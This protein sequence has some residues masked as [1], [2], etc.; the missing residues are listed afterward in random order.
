MRLRRILVGL[1]LVWCRPAAAQQ[2][3][4]YANEPYVVEQSRTSE[5][6]ENDGTGTREVYFR[7]KV[8][9]DAGVQRF[10]QLALG[11][12]A[13]NESIAIQFVRVR[14]PDGTVITTPLDT[15]QDLSSPV[16]R[17]AP[18][19][20]DF[21]QKHVTVE[22]IR[23]GDTL[24]ADVITTIKTALA[25]GEFWTEYSF[26]QRDISLD[27]QFDLD[28]PASRKIIL[29]VQPGFD[30]TT[31]DANGRRIYHWSHANTVRKDPSDA[32]KKKPRSSTEPERASVRVTTFADW[33]AVG[34][35]FAG[36]E[37]NARTITPEI[38]QKARELTAGKPTDLAK[39]EALYDFVSK[40]F[41]YVSLSLGAGRYQP[42]AASDVLKD[43][44]GDC[45]DKATLLAALIQASGMQASPVLI[46]SSVKLDPDFPSPSQFDHV[47]TRATLNGRE[48]WLD[49]TPQ[50]APFRLLAPSLRDKQALLAAPGSGSHL[51]ETPGDT[52]FPA[53]TET[54]VSG[55]LDDSGTLSADVTLTFRGDME[56]AMRT[57]FHQAPAA[58][59][60]PLL[61]AV[62]R[63][64]G[65]AG[66]VS[67]IKPS[68]PLDT[69]SAFSVSFHVRSPDF[70]ELAGR[71]LDV[72]LPMSASQTPADPP[73]DGSI[74]L[75]AAG[76]AVYSL[77][78][79]V[80]AGVRIQLPVPVNVTR[81]Y[82]EYH[83]TYS[84]AGAVL[85]ASRTLVLHQHELPQTRRSDYLAFVHVIEGD[86]NQKVSLDATALTPPAA[87]AGTD[88]K[89]LSTRAY[90]ALQAGD[91]EQSAAM[92]EQLL[93]ADPKDQNARTSL[94]SAYISLHQPQK[95]L[96]VLRQQ[97]AQ[98]PY[99]EY[100]YFYMGR[101]Y[102][103]EHQYAD[104]EAAFNKQLEINPLDKFVPGALGA[105]D[106]ERGQYDKAAAA[107][108]RAVSL[109]PDQW[110][111]LVQLGKAY[112]NLHRIADAQNAFDRAVQIAPA[113]GTWNDVAYEMALGGIN[114]DTAQ[115]YAE[116]AVAAESAASRNLDIQQ[117]DDR[118]LGV[119][120]GLASFWDTL[121]WVH[122][123]KGDL[124]GAEPYVRAAWLLG[125]T[126]DVADHLGQ[127]FEKQG[128]RDEALRAY[129]EAAAAPDPENDVRP[130]L[131]A[132]ARGDKAADA[133]VAKYRG[134][135]AASMTFKLPG[136]GRSGAKADVVVLFSA[137]AT[138]EAVRVVGGDQDLGP[139]IDGVKTLHIPGMFPDASPAKLLRRGTV[140]C[141]ADKS[142]AL[143][144]TLSGDAKPIK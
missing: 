45:K 117:V 89:E 92:Y 65:E 49:A 3:P 99:D 52:P 144:L 94:G 107:Y 31:H 101:A 91:Y 111:P 37:Q 4:S 85:T 41:R 95:A 28:V 93:K 106:I 14:K 73:E 53:L 32:D 22:S 105:M 126:S 43:A 51:V 125:E 118:A 109:N 123:A 44:Y 72:P 141:A 12:N 112:I 21:R 6:F 78:L 55:S 50:E 80:P 143:T 77:S 42:R 34:N 138:V 75:G 25:P 81:D 64:E 36:M 57:I 86:G 5:R 139:V 62:A 90:A 10:G 7:I 19:Y 71:R 122:F 96:E 136:T 129:A 35:W 98:N 38:T 1:C 61:E 104:A 124:A 102:A 114:L 13:A 30:P 8:Q 16:Q 46:N 132:L 27:E 120:S 119:V 121:G 58:R 60:Q 17:I 87:A 9:T 137:P 133:L 18:V 48:I 100:A 15:V 97:V 59:W 83:S 142:C 56:V 74:E 23:P 24:E 40:N 88:T 69:S 115:R 108:E 135:A 63:Q 140:T 128:K 47:I 26:D 134:D 113:P 70:V 39:L 29:K 68:D 79:T 33:T 103:T 82:G 116:S 67:D 2:P 54:R 110:Y 20:T 127:I 76:D 84:S 11:Y 66:T 131:V 130:H